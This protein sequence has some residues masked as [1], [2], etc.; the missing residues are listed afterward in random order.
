MQRTF[1]ALTKTQANGA[2]TFDLTG[3][4]RADKHQIQL[5]VSATPSAGTMSVAIRTP[6][7]SDYVTLGT[8]DMVNGPLAAQ[9]V[10]YAD[11]IK[12]TPASFDADKTYSAYIFT[13]QA[14]GAHAG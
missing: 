9:W 11:S 10:G 1:K 6:G 3:Y 12:L 13:L 7:A 5:D 2:Q 8:I 14:G 4:E